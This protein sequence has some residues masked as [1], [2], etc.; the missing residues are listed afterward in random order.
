LSPEDRNARIA[1][2]RRTGQHGVSMHP[3]GDMVRFDWG[4]RTLCAIE[5]E[6]LADDSTEL[7]E[8]QFVRE[9]PEDARELTD[10]L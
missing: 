1:H 7:P 10:D 8:P 9:V 5:R 2:C 3:E 4:G 6:V